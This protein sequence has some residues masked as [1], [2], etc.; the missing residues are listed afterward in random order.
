MECLLW[1]RHCANSPNIKQI[2]I[3]WECYYYPHFT[4]GEMENPGVGWTAQAHTD[5]RGKSWDRNHDFLI[6]WFINS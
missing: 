1:A 4:S 5:S 3:K 2:D 6:P